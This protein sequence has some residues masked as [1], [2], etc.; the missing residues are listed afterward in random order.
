VA[1]RATAWATRPPA[2]ADP[3]PRADRPS[4]GPA[5]VVAEAW[6]DLRKFQV[7]LAQLHDTA[8]TVADPADRVSVT[9]RGG[10]L[11]AV[12]PD[13]SWTEGAG[14]VDLADRLG[15]ALRAGLAAVDGLPGRALDASPLLRGRLPGSS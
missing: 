13:P 12:T 4:G 6:R 10:R 14:D 5:D 2:V 3:P 8:V 11:V 7:R 1:A 15:E 9:V